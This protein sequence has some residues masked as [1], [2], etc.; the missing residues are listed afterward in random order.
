MPCR[1]WFDTQE[2]SYRDTVI[3]PTVGARVSVEAGV[4]QGWREIVGDRGRIVSVE[5]YGASAPYQRIYEA[6]GITA[7]AVADAARDSIAA[8]S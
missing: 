3:P 6:Y 2:Q 5:T 4:A 1:E 8:N 7:T